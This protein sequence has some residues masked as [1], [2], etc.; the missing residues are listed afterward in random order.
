M[1]KI[2][3]PK[4]IETH[5]VDEILAVKIPKQLMLSLSDDW[6]FFVDLKQVKA[7]SLDLPAL[8]LSKKFRRY[9][10]VENIKEINNHIRD[11]NYWDKLE[12]L[13]KNSL[14]LLRSKKFNPKNLHF[15]DNDYRWYAFRK[16]MPMSHPEVKDY[17]NG[18][19]NRYYDLQKAM[20]ILKKSRWVSQIKEV[21]I[22]Y[23]NR[24]SDYT[25]AIEFI[26]K[27][28]QKVLDK[29]VRY[30]RDEQK[31]EFWTLKVRDCVVAPY[32]LQPF[33]VLGL[34]AALKKLK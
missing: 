4:Q 33:D 32:E 9:S 30:Y 16:D 24:E 34:S 17:I 1:V 23:Y 12:Q 11:N 21:E 25:D 3:Q 10:Y 15:F 14:K 31:E 5:T 26:I 28:P 7:K 20:K 8:T 29:L 27:L 2:I 22:P 18:V 13:N 6:F 19:V